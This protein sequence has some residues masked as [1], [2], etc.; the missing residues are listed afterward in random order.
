MGRTKIIL[1]PIAGRGY[2]AKAEPEIRRMLEAEQ[3]DFEMEPT[4]GPGHAVELAK[5]A[6]QDGFDLIVAA[7][8]DGTTHEVMNGL[9]ASANDSDKGQGKSH[10]Q[11]HGRVVGTLGIL[12]LGSGCDFANT[13]GVPSELLSACRRLVDGQDRIVDVVQVTLPGQEVRYF[14]N[15]LNIG[16]GGTV[17]REA[18]KIKYLRG[19]A[20]YLPVVLKTVFLY[21]NAPRVTIQTDDEELT[22]PVV[23][24]S[25]ANGSREGGGF[26]VAPSALPDDGLLDLCIVRKIGRL[27]MLG[28]IP[29]FMKGTHVGNESVIMMNARHVRISSP[30]DLIA[31]ID[32]EMLCTDAHQ[33]DFEIMPGRL[34]VRC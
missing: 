10:G 4:A 32:G 11:G 26:F 18:R 23:M 28:L 19:M 27:A 1:N 8:G 31:H 5:Q 3:L 9:M 25:I 33:I 29:H 34:R 17:T 13:V 2:A 6:V 22:L 30:D 15:T 21:L 16:F 24:V 14:D 20:L 7:G 12:P